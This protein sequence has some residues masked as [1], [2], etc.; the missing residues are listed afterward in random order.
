MSGVDFVPG[1]FHAEALKSASCK[2]GTVRHPLEPKH[3]HA[4]T[5][6]AA[7]AERDVFAVLGGWR[8]P[9]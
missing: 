1:H 4:T 9:S 8:A 5:D 3:D 2:R 6:L 7:D